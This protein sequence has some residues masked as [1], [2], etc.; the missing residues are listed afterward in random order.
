MTKKTMTQILESLGSELLT[1]EVKA[2]IV[3]SFDNAVN[4]RVNERVELEV[5]NQLEKIDEDH[6][7]KVEKLIEAIDENHTNMFKNVVS[8]ID[9]AHTKKLQTVVKKF[10]TEM[11]ENAESFK[12]QLVEKISK[13]LD[14]KID[15]LIPVDH[16][17]EAVEN[18][19]ARKLV[20][21]IKKIV[22]YD[23]ESLTPEFKEALKEGHDTIES[24]RKEVNEKTKEVMGITEQLNTLKANVLLE[25][26]LQGL[27]ESKKKFITKF[28]TGKAPEYIENNF[29]YVVEMFEEDES[30]K[31]DLLKEQAKSKSVSKT[32]TPPP[33]K[34]VSEVVTESSETESVDDVS[35]Y[36]KDMKEQDSFYK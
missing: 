36:L 30:N 20:N 11:N 28:M 21:E 7:E 18:I 23:P 10:Q 12:G 16:L 33:S 6:T 3:E 31:A 22:S 2:A 32:V 27:S 35:Q 15:S 1:D 34:L 17:K 13:F 25:G 4:E 29:Q 14:L 24:L 19:E 9:E 8:K 26:K 5:K